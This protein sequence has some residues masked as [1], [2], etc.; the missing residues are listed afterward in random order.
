[1]S[2]SHAR[3][4]RPLRV[5][6]RQGTPKC[7]SQT[8]PQAMLPMPGSGAP[9]SRQAPGQPWMRKR[10][11]TPRTKGLDLT[12]KVEGCRAP[13]LL[14]P[15]GGGGAPKRWAHTLSP[16]RPRTC[17]PCWPGGRRA[18]R[19]SSPGRGGSGGR[20]AP[21]RPAAR[22]AAAAAPPARTTPWLP[23]RVPLRIPLRIARWGPLRPRPASPEALAP[24]P[25]G[26]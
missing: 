19:G 7:S 26:A 25:P 3:R 6:W 14:T 12:L 8:A 1:M 10:K 22:A 17:A 2:P 5:G 23:R 15:Q 11:V 18:G 24:A 4:P 16:P 9:R 21:R 20:P 13:W